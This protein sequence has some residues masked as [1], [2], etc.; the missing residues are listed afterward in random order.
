MADED[1]STQ[2]KPTPG[3]TASDPG[4]ADHTADDAEPAAASS[5]AAKAEAEAEA[6]AQ[7]PI[8]TLTGQSHDPAEA[9]ASAHPS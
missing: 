8:E 5:P 1:L 4:A 6:E 3:A 2:P 9:E 7:N